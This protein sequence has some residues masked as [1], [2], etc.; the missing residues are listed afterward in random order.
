MAA[1]GGSGEEVTA[2][3][4]LSAYLSSI[5]VAPGGNAQLNIS[6]APCTGQKLKLECCHSLDRAKCLLSLDIS[7][8]SCPHSL[9]F[10][11]PVDWEAGM[12]SIVL[13]VMDEGLEGRIIEWNDWSGILVVKPGDVDAKNICGA[14][15]L[16]ATQRKLEAP[17]PPRAD[18][19]NCTPYSLCLV[20]EP[21]TN[22]SVTRY[23]LM[24]V[25]CMVFLCRFYLCTC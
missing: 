16:P 10:R 13:S 3:Q 19:P 7:C 25:F 23:R 18:V 12:Y 21:L 22:P 9:K 4:V 17:S 11:V 15:A 6:T 5:S 14:Q 8:P 1:A 2:V 24:Q 20:V